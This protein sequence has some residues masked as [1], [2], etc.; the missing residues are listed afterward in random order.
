MFRSAAYLYRGGAIGVVLSG[1]LSDGT[2]GLWTIKR[3]GGT[4]IVL[5]PEDAPYPSMPLSALKDVHIDY[6]LPVTEIA[7]VLMKRIKQPIAN[8]SAARDRQMRRVEIEHAIAGGN[9]PLDEGVFELGR[10]SRYSCPE[11]HGVLGHIE[12][13]TIT[14]Y[15]C[16]TGHAY[17]QDALLTSLHEVSDETL[18]QTITAL[19]ASVMLL[20]EIATRSSNE[21]NPA[22]A[23]KY[24]RRA[25]LTKDLL[26]G[27][28]NF[29][30]RG[31]R[32]LI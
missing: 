17:M 23:K 11:C 1:A 22:A 6:S 7:E 3:P 5:H 10:S 19:E 14:R 21:R 25:Q 31:R 9:L 27:L 4:T 16:H 13:G 32:E 15:R 29:L 26:K 24:S 8:V 2:S 18:A 28:R 30:L 20:E 12:E